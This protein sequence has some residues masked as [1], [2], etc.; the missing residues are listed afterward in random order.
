MEVALLCLRSIRSVVRLAG[1]PSVDRI[2]GSRTS[3]SATSSIDLDLVSLDKLGD[4]NFDKDAREYL[5]R[6]L[7]RF[8]RVDG[9][10]LASNIGPPVC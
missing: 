6:G 1:R 5:V 3:T 9:V 7:A 2:F 4:D 10:V 8:H